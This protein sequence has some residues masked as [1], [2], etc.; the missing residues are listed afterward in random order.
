MGGF[1]ISRENEIL[2]IIEKNPTISQNEISEKLGITRSSVSVHITNLMKKGAIKGRGYIVDKSQYV[3][4]IGGANN[5]LQ[6]F[7]KGKFKLSDSNPG[8]IKMSSGGVGR[9]ISENLSKLDVR[10]KL[11]TALGDDL[12]GNK[13]FQEAEHSNIDMSDSFILKGHSTS[14]YMS[15]LD[16][17]GD[18]IAAI[19]HMDIYDYLT[20]ELIKEKKNTID[21]SRVCVLDTNLREDVLSYILNNHKNVEFFLDTVST[22]KAMKVKNLIGKFHTIKLNKIEAEMLSDIKINDE[23]DLKNVS[24]YFLNK[25]VKR[26]FITLG[27]DGV[28]YNDGT[29]INHVKQPSIKVVN[30]TGAGDAFTSALIYCYLEDMDL[31]YSTKFSIATA[32]LA[33]SH[34]NTINP[35]LNINLIKEKMEELKLC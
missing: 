23:N 5:D 14:T 28:Y 16:D 35:N 7:P 20:I 19:S 21:N 1:N 13:I 33:L 25:G 34:E 2:K 31:E 26:V 12:Y 22:S 17:E 30:A 9:N 8:I 18:M 6:G 29:V 27:K 32:V 4:V 11:I 3:C 24:A 15:I 10:V